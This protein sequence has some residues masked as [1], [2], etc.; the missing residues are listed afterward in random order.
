[1]KTTRYDYANLILFIILFATTIT[2]YLVSFNS[3]ENKGDI[4]LSGILTSTFAM[5][6]CPGVTTIWMNNTYNRLMSKDNL[7]FYGRTDY[8]HEYKTEAGEHFRGT[9]FFFL[10]FMSPA[11]VAGDWY[12]AILFFVI[13]LIF[14]HG[15]NTNYNRLKRYVISHSDPQN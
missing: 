9:I 3:T 6:V 11:L 12:L 10:T 2:L 8:L 14:F 4:V 5:F 13:A 1:M 15:V 7:S